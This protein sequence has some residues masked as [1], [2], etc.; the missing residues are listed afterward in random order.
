MSQWFN[1]LRMQLGLVASPMRHL[2]GRSAI[3]RQQIRTI[4]KRVPV[5]VGQRRAFCDALRRGAWGDAMSHIPA[6]TLQPS[7]KHPPE[8]SGI[9]PRLEFVVTIGEWIDNEA[10]ANVLRI[11]WNTS[12]K[13]VDELVFHALFDRLPMGH[14]IIGL[15]HDEQAFFHSQP[16]PFPVLRGCINSTR[17]GYCWTTDHQTAVRFAGLHASE[18]EEP[19]VILSGICPK[20]VVRAVYHDK[21]EYE[22]VV[23]YHQLLKVA[24]ID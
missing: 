19:P 4:T 16:D 6:A 24:C 12:E 18:N 21:G 11:A 8:W 10:Y 3:T 23:A 2:L 13:Y 22:V 20:D 14:N 5:M 17:D 9:T 7:D 1:K 15:S